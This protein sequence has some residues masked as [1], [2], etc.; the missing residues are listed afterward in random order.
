VPRDQSYW[1]SN[2]THDYV[3]CR[4]S[5]LLCDPPT[6]YPSQNDVS[7]MNSLY[8]IDIEWQIPDLP[9]VDSHEEPCL[10]VD[11]SVFP[12]LEAI[13][14]GRQVSFIRLQDVPRLKEPDLA[15]GG[16]IIMLSDGRTKS[17]G[18]GDVPHCR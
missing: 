10:Y 15:L 14:G 13:V 2:D 7:H 3:F 16:L 17:E 5:F 6:T 9:A 11:D 8:S 4:L 12:V 1:T 18:R